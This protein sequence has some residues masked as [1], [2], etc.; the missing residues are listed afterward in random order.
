MACGEM[1]VENPHK[2]F[3]TADEGPDETEDVFEEE[4]EEL[5]VITEYLPKF[6]GNDKDS[7]KYIA[8]KIR[9]PEEAIEKGIEGKVFVK[10]LVK[11]NGEVDKVQIA[12]GVHPLLDQEALR[13]I[14]TM[15]NW[16]PAPSRV[17]VV[18]VWM[19]V[20]VYF[21]LD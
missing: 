12:R 16:M 18:D 4:E 5:F 9:Y 8:S 3:G 6:R 20:P 19:T 21:S 10:F 14:K 7:K 2:N 1:S 11:R 17:R 13:V 15:P